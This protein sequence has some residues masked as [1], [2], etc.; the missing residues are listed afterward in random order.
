MRAVHLRMLA[1]G[2]YPHEPASASADTCPGCRA[3][4][5][6]IDLDGLSPPDDIGTAL[7]ASYLL[8]NPGAKL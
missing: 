2:K 4:W 5:L 1:S 7:V 8:S 6:A 3:F